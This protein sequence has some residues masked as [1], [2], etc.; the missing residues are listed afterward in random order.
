[1]TDEIKTETLPIQPMNVAIVGSTGAGDGGAPI[2][3]GTT[4]KTPDHQPN[5]VFTVVGP[6]R[7]IGIRFINTFLTGF[8]G[9]LSGA[10]LIDKIAGMQLFEFSDLQDLVLKSAIAALAPA[11]IGLGKDLITIFGKLESKY[12]LLTGNI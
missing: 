5:V 10:P 4:A 6:L 9:F 7:A 3:T 2:T 8:V 12:P 11:V 1:M